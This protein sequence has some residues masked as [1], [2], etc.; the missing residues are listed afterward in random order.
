[1]VVAKLKAVFIYLTKVTF[2]PV[3]AVEPALLIDDV[4]SLTYRGS[5]M[6]HLL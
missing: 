6:S 5:C 2:D 1:M 4:D 3:G